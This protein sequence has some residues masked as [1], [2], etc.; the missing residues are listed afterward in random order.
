MRVHR[1][2]KYETPNQQKIAAAAAAEEK[3]T[4]SALL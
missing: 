4:Q 1:Q 2:V 3:N